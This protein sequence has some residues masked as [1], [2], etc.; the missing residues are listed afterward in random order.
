M[1]HLSDPVAFTANSLKIDRTKALVE[2]DRQDS[3]HSLSRFVRL[4]WPIVELSEPYVHGWHIDAICEH[5]EAVSKGQIR[6]LLINVPPG[7]MKSF[8]V[9]V[10]WPAWE[11]GAAGRPEYKYISASHEQ[12]LAIRDNLRMK[13]LVESDWYQQRWPLSMMDDQNAKTKFDNEYLGFRQACAMTSMTGHRG[14]RIICDDPQSAFDSLSDVKRKAATI[15]MK[16]TIPTRLI[17]PEKSVIVVIMQRLHQSDVSGY[18][19]AEKLGYDHLCLPMRYEAER[20]CITSIGWTDPRTKEGELLFPQRYPENIVQEL[21]RSLGSLASA[22][23]LQQRP[24]PRTGGFFRWDMVPVVKTAPPLK[25]IVRYWDKAGTDVNDGDG[26][27]YTAGVKMGIGDDGKF[28]VLH[29]TRFQKEA[30]ERERIMKQTAKM[31]GKKT[32]VWI[33]QEPGSGGKESAQATI[34]N[35][36]GFVVRAE[37][38]HGAKELRAEPY[39]VQMEAGNIVMVEGDWNT[40]FIE[41]HKI[42]P[43]GTYKDQV[44]AAAGAFNKLAPS[45]G[46]S[47]L[48]MGGEKVKLGMAS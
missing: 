6:R 42:F 33:E 12:S 25:K 14:D 29:V 34:R 22:G 30:A 18:I 40:D 21:E 32:Q 17:N 35:L 26:G 8:L 43:V 23:Q 7:M 24:S 41:E 36:A 48:S 3:K 10:F 47:T 44:D 5:L 2:L 4:A 45:V 19:L 28:Y 11:W 13:R 39:S 1:N 31:D 15:V 9:N 20:K 37:K 46:K 16:E 38:V 27:C